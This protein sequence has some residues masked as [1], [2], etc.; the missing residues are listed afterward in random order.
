MLAGVLLTL[1]T[2]KSL[3]VIES[4]DANVEVTVARP[5]KALQIN[6]IQALASV[7]AI[8]SEIV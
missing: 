5:R 6:E 7:A 3:F 8:P 1:E 4:S 2:Q